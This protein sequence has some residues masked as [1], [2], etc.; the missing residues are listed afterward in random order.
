MV[1]LQI[2]LELVAFEKIVAY[3]SPG[4]QWLPYRGTI[5]DRN[6]KNSIQNKPVWNKSNFFLMIPSFVFLKKVKTKFLAAASTGKRKISPM[7]EFYS[8]VAGH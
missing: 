4:G 5:T 2:S 1:T 8:E 3:S 7:C 6:R